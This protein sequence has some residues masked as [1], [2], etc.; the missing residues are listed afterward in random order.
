MEQAEPADE[1][2][3]AATRSR[4]VAFALRSDKRGRLTGLAGQRITQIHRAAGFDVTYVKADGA[5]SRAIKAPGEGEPQLPPKPATVIP[6][7][8]VRVV[9]EPLT[10]RVAHRVE[11]ISA[12]TG[13]AP[14][15]EIK[16]EHVARLLSHRCGA[17][18]D[19]DVGARVIPLLT[20]VDDAEREA[21]AED[22]ARRA[23]QLTDRFDRVV[24]ASYRRPNP[25]VG[26]RS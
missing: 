24:L 22:V 14:G 2:I 10:D 8:S 13:L 21:L 18:K 3:E 26:V 11:R 6:V 16:A 1:V 15:A 20:C 17:L 5:R 9:G 12:L 4:V 7:V 23:L 19:L 25:L